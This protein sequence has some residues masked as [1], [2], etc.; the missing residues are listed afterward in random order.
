VIC[1]REKVLALHRSG[2]SLGTIANNLNLSKTTVYRIV[3]QPVL[4][5]HA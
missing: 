5:A 3:T 4:T 2:Q 1:D